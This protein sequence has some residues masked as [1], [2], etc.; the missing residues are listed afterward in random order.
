MKPLFK[1]SHSMT[2]NGKSNNPVFNEQALLAMRKIKPD[3]KGMKNVFREL[4]KID[5]IY[6][7]KIVGKR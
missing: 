5:F 1:I 3:K 6:K 4:K 7:S 2:Y